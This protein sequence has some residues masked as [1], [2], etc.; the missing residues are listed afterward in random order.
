MTSKSPG[1]EVSA[2][3]FT[4]CPNGRMLNNNGTNHEIC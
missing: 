1:S 2:G 4:L 3:F